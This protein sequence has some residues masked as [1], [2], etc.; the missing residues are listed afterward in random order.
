MKKKYDSFFFIYKLGFFGYIWYIRFD[1]CVKHVCHMT[2]MSK[3]MDLLCSSLTGG[4]AYG[5][6]LPH[7]L[8][9]YN[10][11]FPLIELY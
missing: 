6:N 9:M 1:G 4:V 10:F 3:L 5:R 7:Y 8:Q 11:L 2:R